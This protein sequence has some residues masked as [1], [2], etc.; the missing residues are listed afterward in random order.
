MS[1]MSSAYLS[2]LGN[3][4]DIPDRTFHHLGTTWK[5]SSSESTSDVKELIPEFFYFPE[6]LLNRESVCACACVRVCVRVCGCTC[7][8]ICVC[9]SFIG[10][11]FGERQ[12][13]ERVDHVTLP[14]WSNNDPRLFIL[15]HRQVGNSQ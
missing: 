2:L 5:L 12:S 11:M 13:G 3:S 6:F 1:S 4:F 9:M 8:Y 10:F 15:K 14:P 7:M